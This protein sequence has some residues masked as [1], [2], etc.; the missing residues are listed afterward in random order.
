MPLTANSPA[1]LHVLQNVA[2]ISLAVLL[3][4]LCTSIA[5]LSSVISPFT[6]ATRQIQ[7]QRQGRNKFSDGQPRTVLVTGV[8][9]SKGLFIARAFYK[10]GYTVIGADF[11]PF[12]IPVCGRFSR[13]LQKFFSLSKPSDISGP[14]AY[15]NRLVDVIRKEDVD[16][17]IS[18]SGV[19]SALEDGEAAEAVQSTTSCRVVQFGMD[20]TALLHE[21]HSF[22]KNTERLQLNVPETHPITSVDQA[23]HL[24][25]PAKG[26]LEKSF[27]MKS[28]GLDDSIRA[29]MTLLPFSQIEKTRE[30]LAT[31]RPSPSRPFVLQQWIDGP[32]FCTHSII[33]RGRVLAFTCCPSSELLMHYK[34][35]PTSSSIFR[36]LLKYTEIYAERIGSDMTGH[37]S[38]DFLI[39]QESPEKD[40]MKKVYPI[41]CNP[42]AHTAVVLFAKQSVQMAQAYMEIFNVESD[43]KRDSGIVFT[44]SDIGYYW[45]GHDLVTRILLPLA[46][47]LTFEMQFS[48][49]KSNWIEF[50]RRILYWRDGI[51]EIWD[52]WPFWALYCIYWPCIFISR[53]FS[54]KKWSRCNVSTTKIFDC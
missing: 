12:Y 10:A 16:L 54:G 37:F 35:L 17:W 44:T 2:L 13:A 14:R 39:D 27:I 53:I 20:M 31:L 3:A 9:M 5:I 43:L 19:A 1:W 29:D 21:K 18:C 28:V 24:L 47:F 32:E 38:I 25:H 26:D 23:I 11:E 49:L 15:I 33:I 50:F 36:T 46:A 4:P 51:F 6:Q 8:G 22:I 48:E 42:R 40:L 34:A 52:P 30:H 45:I 41:E 7:Q